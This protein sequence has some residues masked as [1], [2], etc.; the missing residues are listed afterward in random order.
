MSTPT[1]SDICR[2]SVLG[3]Q[4]RLD[5]ALPANVPFADLFPT[6]ARYVGIDRAGAQPPG[7]W[8]L[9]RLGEPPFPLSATP[10]QVGLRDGELVYLRPRVEQLPEMAFDD[11]AD[12]IGSAVNDRPGRWGP[13]DTRLSAL[14]AGALAL[15][16]GVAV[17]LL[18]GPPWTVPA[19]AAGAV[20][21]LL[22]VAGTA[23]SRAGG[24]SAAGAVLGYAALPYALLAGL[25]APARNSSLS[26]LGSLHMLSGAATLSL[27]AVIAAGAIAGG[28][29]VFFGTTAAALALIAAG[30]LDTVGQVGTAGAAAVVATAALALTPLIPAV[31]FRAVR[32]NLPP[33]PRDADDLRRDTM[34][35]EGKRLLDQ[36]ARADRMVSAGVSGIGLVSAGAEVALAFS[37][38]LLPRAT[39]AALGCALLLRS[40]MFRGRAQRLW[41]LVPGYGGLSLIAVSA[42]LGTGTGTAARPVVLG[43]AL[44]ALLAGAC[45]VIGSGVW[46]S[47][48]RPSPFWGRAAD[49]IDIMLIVSLIPLALAVAG[50]FGHIRGLSG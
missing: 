39:A 43:L 19:L 14:G 34:N 48:H 23:A 30:A 16:A 3:P 17:V 22:L 42:S 47:S 2:I 21:M 31:S 8:V 25:L 6:I 1:R 37:H 12:V 13:A 33:V 32:L 49:V 28:I 4:R 35:V 11:V 26:H 44:V 15:L 29:P 36:T 24:D 20:A 18:S 38:G 10:S 7:G 41:L 5:I 9:Q 45:L 46:A 27:A 50:L 40:R